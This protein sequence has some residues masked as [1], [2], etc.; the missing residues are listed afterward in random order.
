MIIDP[1]QWPNGWID[2]LATSMLFGASAFARCPHGGRKT[3]AAAQVLPPPD[4]ARHGA[5]D[6]DRERCRQARFWLTHIVRGLVT[7]E[8]TELILRAFL[9]AGIVERTSRDPLALVA[10]PRSVHV[11]IVVTDV[12][13]FTS[14]SEGTAPAVVFEVLNTVQGALADIVRRHD[15]TVD[16]FTGDGMLAVFGLNGGDHARHALAAVA[17]MRR[18]GSGCKPC[19][20]CGLLSTF[21]SEWASIA[22]RFSSAVSAARCGWSLR[23][24]VTS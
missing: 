16:K 17:D 22:G 13:G 23:S 15:G 4:D 5:G 8:V 11:T 6:A 20:R 3:N 10:E 12:R 24:L 1:G 19:R 14:F 18:A 7:N 2:N 21:G 9:P